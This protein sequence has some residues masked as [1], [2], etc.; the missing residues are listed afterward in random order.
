M[1]MSVQPAQPLERAMNLSG[2][3]DP[4]IG[5][6]VTAPYREFVPPA[7]TARPLYKG[8]WLTGWISAVSPDAITLDAVTVHGSGSHKLKMMNGSALEIAYTPQFS[9]ILP[10]SRSD[11]P[12]RSSA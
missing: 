2:G 10:S 7:G 11:P 12:S 4:V 1:A 8:V 9:G 5:L 6:P 3:L